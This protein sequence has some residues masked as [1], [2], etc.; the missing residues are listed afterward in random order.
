M[1]AFFFSVRRR[2]HRRRV[3]RLSPDRFARSAMGERVSGYVYGTIV[4]LSVI[5]GGAKAYP[6]EPGH[7]AVVVAVTCAVFWLAHV[8]AHGIGHA[9]HRNEHLSFADLLAI[10]RREASV[11][12][13]AVLP[14]AA[15]V[16]GAIGVFGAKTSVWI[17][18]VLGLVVLA[19]QGVV[20]ARVERLGWLATA[21]VVAANLGLG[22]VLVLLKLFVSH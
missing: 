13:A 8:Y 4:A 17:A 18:F 10:A 9:V 3:R 21:G 19:A 20:F 7:I 16:L 5:V 15:L 6:H 14:I 22:L 11:I 12:E 2:S 1:R